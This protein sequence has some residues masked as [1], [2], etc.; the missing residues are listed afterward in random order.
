[1]ILNKTFLQNLD[2]IP[3]LYCDI[4]RCLVLATFAQEVAFLS[5]CVCQSAG[6][7]KNDL[8]DFGDTLG[9]GMIPSNVW[10]GSI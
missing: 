7:H 1:M 9:C 6:L 4:D 2:F 5:V 3:V 8:T 10:S